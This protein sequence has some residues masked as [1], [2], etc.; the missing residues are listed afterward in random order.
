MLRPCLSERMPGRQLLGGHSVWTLQERS[1]GAPTDLSVG[2]CI[3]DCL[4]CRCDAGR[5]N[6]MATV[7]QRL[8]RHMNNRYAQPG[9]FPWH[10]HRAGRSISSRIFYPV[11]AVATSTGTRWQ[12]SLSA[13]CIRK[14]HCDLSFL[15]A[16]V[17]CA[18]LSQVLCST[19]KD[20]GT[21]V[22]SAGCDKQVKM[23]PLMQAGAQATTVGVHDAPIK[24]ISWIPEM[25]L[26][27][28]ASWDKSLRLE[29]CR[30]CCTRGL[31]V[32]HVLEVYSGAV[33][34]LLS[35]ESRG[36]QNLVA[37]GMSLSEAGVVAKPH[38]LCDRL[39]WLLRQMRLPC[40]GY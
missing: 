15:V 2:L 19:W 17:A 39:F 16:L 21:T 6:R 8:G 20:D 26:L 22:F 3:T 28:T 33:D 35:R 30:H 13:A 31:L 7:F 1:C 37:P 4:S 32:A 29:P 34:G 40:S 11:I 9:T 5:F 24:D 12:D 23:W 25:Q 14:A 27:V 38:L 36:W 18:S 10:F